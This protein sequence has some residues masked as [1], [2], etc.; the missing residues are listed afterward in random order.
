MVVFKMNLD[1]IVNVSMKL[2]C[3]SIEISYTQ[4]QIFFK[5]C[6]CIHPFDQPQLLTLCTLVVRVKPGLQ[7]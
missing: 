6:K 7:H 5:K 1:Q 2:V 4:R 3:V